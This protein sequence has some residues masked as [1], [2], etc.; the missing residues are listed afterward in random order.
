MG[1]LRKFIS[2]DIKKMKINLKN[3]TK[4]VLK[5]ISDLSVLNENTDTH[6]HSVYFHH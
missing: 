6:T 2:M 5:S 3:E 4:L 1:V